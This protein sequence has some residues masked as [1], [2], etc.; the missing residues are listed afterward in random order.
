VPVTIY[1]EDTR[2]LAGIVELHCRV[3]PQALS[4]WKLDTIQKITAAYFARL[5]EWE[6]RKQAS[7][8]D[9]A[10]PGPRVDLEALCR[11][12]CISS[13]LGAWPSAGGR[14]DDLHGG[15]PVPG[16]LAGQTGVLVEFME[17]AFEWSNLQYVAYPYYW[18][19]A[20]RWDQL[21][22][23]DDSDPHV[24]EFLRSGAVRIV[25]PVTLNMAD[26]VLFYL[27]TGIPWSG[28]PA[29]MPGESGYR[30][31]ADE[32]N[33]SRRSKPSDEPVS[34]FRY[35]LPTSLT[36]LQETGDLPAP[37]V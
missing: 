12:S 15:W 2:G 1:A 31:I 7:A 13:L 19:D 33:E 3:S 27:G 24:R 25:V 16:A 5:S 9:V 10:A 6:A 4:R 14:N 11:H 28:G 37:P 18:A 29:P 30:A 26:S 34:E 35:T 23:V 8:F 17:Q 20:N 21:L 32:I 36:I 22:A